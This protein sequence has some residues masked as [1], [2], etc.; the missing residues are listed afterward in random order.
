MRAT[1][2]FAG[3]LDA[4]TSSTGRRPHSADVSCRFL[5]EL[6]IEMAE[7][8]EVRPTNAEPDE[9]ITLA[10]YVGD[11]YKP[12]GELNTP[13]EEGVRLMDKYLPIRLYG[14]ELNPT[15][16]RTIRFYAGPRMEDRGQ[17]YYRRFYSEANK[18]L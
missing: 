8:P 18:A 3:Q 7:V 15:K 12:S 16:Y 11:M 13:Y 6:L 10:T 9:L 17:N 14:I 4:F 2:D 1:M 5:A